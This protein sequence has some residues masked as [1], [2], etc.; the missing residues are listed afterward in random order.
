MILS[1]APAATYRN[2]GTLL[3]LFLIG[4]CCSS[5]EKK[6]DTG[7]DEKVTALGSFE[8]TA[9]LL[10][11]PGKF[12][13]NDLYDYAYVLK[14]KVQMVH[15]GKIDS[16]II[17]VGHYN[18]LKQRSQAAD[19]R[20][21]EVGGNLKKFRPDDLHRMALEVPIDDNYMGGIIDKYFDTN[22]GPVY[23]AIWTNR[24]IN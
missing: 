12:P 23:W 17:Y 20:A 8:I 4:L 13:P 2:N 11:I 6:T 22:T 1:T 16:D 7:L 3:L 18:P 24:V 15:R 19:A 14:Y 5:C 10:K 21:P 9:K